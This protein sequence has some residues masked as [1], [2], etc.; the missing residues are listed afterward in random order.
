VLVVVGLVV[1]EGESVGVGVGVGVEPGF[2][3]GVTVIE[4]L[5][6]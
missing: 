2:K 6:E 3:L 1:G 4:E 5:G